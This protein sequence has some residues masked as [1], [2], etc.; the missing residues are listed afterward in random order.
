MFSTIKRKKSRELKRFGF[1]NERG[2]ILIWYVFM[3]PVFVGGI[4]L[5]VDMTNVTAVR[6]SLQLSLD[7]A[8]QGTV[9]LSKNQTSGKPR[10]LT[11]SQAQAE[12][13]KLYDLNRTGMSK[14]GQ[15][16]EGIPF[17]QCQTKKTGSGTRIVPSGS[18][19]GFTLSSFNYHGNGG[20]K[21]GGHITMTVTE[22][23]D[24]MFLGMLGFD[25]LTYTITSTARLTNTYN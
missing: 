25:D 23:A 18:K 6:T 10:F 3:I 11:K 4:G 17:L 7:A 21:N 8:T 16:K 9:A 12:A 19:C 15:V 2:N 24:T 1:L 20:L 14:A 5:A 13:V 22:K